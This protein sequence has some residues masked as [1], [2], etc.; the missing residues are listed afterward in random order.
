[1]F[2]FLDGVD[3]R[4]VCCVILISSSYF[5]Y[6]LCAVELLRVQYLG[7]C[8]NSKYQGSEVLNYSEFLLKSHP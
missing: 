6:V 5:Y 4:V 2:Y 7:L 8:L 3:A 1:M